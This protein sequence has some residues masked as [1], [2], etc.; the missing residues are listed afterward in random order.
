MVEQRLKY[1]GYYVN[2]EKRCFV[3]LT[4][5]RLESII[6]F[7]S[8]LGVDMLLGYI[9][10]LLAQLDIEGDKPNEHLLPNRDAAS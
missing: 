7:D 6:E 5:N 4:A 10:Q 3:R 8:P 1:R 2:I 9:L